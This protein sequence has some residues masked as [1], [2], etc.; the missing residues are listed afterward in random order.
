MYFF[1]DKKV[2]KSQDYACYAQKIYAR[3]TKSSK[4]ATS[5][6]KQGRFLTLFSLIFGSSVKVGP[7]VNEAVAFESLI[8]RMFPVAEA[9]E[10]TLLSKFR[11]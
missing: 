2:P 1:L 5:L 3:T 10:A 7:R 11:H 8:Q 6:L 9:L 4:L